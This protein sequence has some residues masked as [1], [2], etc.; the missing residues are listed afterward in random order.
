MQISNREKKNFGLQ[1]KDI[2]PFLTKA[3]AQNS[4]GN[5]IPKTV[6]FTYHDFSKVPNYVKE[7]IRKY[8]KGFDIQFYSNKR[9]EEFLQDYLGSR[10]VQ[11]FKNF[12]TGAHKADFWRYCILYFKG[13]YYFDIKVNFQDYISN[14][15]DGNKKN[16]WYTIIDPS[17]VRIHNGIIVTPAFNPIFKKLISYIYKNSKPSYYHEYVV[18]FYQTLK[19]MFGYNPKPGINQYGHLN[20]ILFQES[21]ES[22]SKKDKECDQYGLK[23]VIKDGNKIVFKTRYADFPWK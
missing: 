20:C 9:C 12:E 4:I 14:I 21:C 10:A 15:F 3:E 6:Y 18:N 2:D 5:T 17:K 11:I 23:C 1:L 13:G 16:T 8:C 22:C 7:N 19:T